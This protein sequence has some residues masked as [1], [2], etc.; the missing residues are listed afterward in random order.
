MLRNTLLSSLFSSGTDFIN[1]FVRS[2]IC[3]SSVVTTL[4]SG[5]AISSLINT[6]LSLSRNSK[7][8]VSIINS[9]ASRSVLVL[10]M[11]HDFLLLQ[12]CQVPLLLRL[13][14]GLIPLLNLLH[15]Q[16]QSHLRCY[17]TFVIISFVILGSFCSFGSFNTTKVLVH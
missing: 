7:S 14:L 11:L 6:G 13:L 4:Y 16:Y 1:S 17:V 3:S 5:N 8:F 15:F 2:A 10:L 9:P 12:S